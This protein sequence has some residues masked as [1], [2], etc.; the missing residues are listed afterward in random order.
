LLRYDVVS[1]VRACHGWFCWVFFAL[2]WIILVLF[3]LGWDTCSLGQQE[4]AYGISGSCR[5]PSSPA[6]SCG[7][8]GS[9]RSAPRLAAL[10]RRIY[11]NNSSI[12]LLSSQILKC[13]R[14]ASLLVALP[15]RIYLNNPS[16]NLHTAKSSNAIDPPVS[17]LHSLA[18]FTYTINHLTSIQP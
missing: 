13:H 4:P 1:Y 11:L 18:E 9:H 17:W 15:R 7:A 12:N 14:S 2:V 3:V 5:A 16:I 6:P 10:P 8:S